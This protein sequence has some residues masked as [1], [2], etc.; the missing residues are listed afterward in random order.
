MDIARDVVSCRGE[1]FLTNWPHLDEA[2]VSALEPNAARSM[3]LQLTWERLRQVTPA[4]AG[5]SS[6]TDDGVSKLVSAV[7]VEMGAAPGWWRTVVSNAWVY[8]NGT[9]FYPIGDVMHARSPM[10]G[11]PH[12]ESV[13]NDALT[14]SATF[15]P[16]SGGFPYEL[17]AT[18]NGATSWTANICAA[19]RQSLQGLGAH[20]VELRLEG[21]AVVV[22]GV[23]THG[24]YVEKL[25]LTDGTTQT[26]FS[27]DLWMARQR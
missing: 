12:T 24:A 6:L 15:E 13:K 25:S 18:A 4:D 9:T 11:K 14:V 1:R 22:W 26:R 27:S 21:N 8:D 23:E 16:A 7:E 20:A 10:A 3:N 2:A 17:H 19:G 5:R